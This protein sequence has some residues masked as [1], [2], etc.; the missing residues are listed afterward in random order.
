M[1]VTGVGFELF[2]APLDVLFASREHEIDQAC[3]LMSSGFDGSWFV[4]SSQ[5]RAMSCADEGLASAGVD[6]GHSQGLSGAVDEL[7]SAPGE[8]FLSAN[9]RPWS[10]R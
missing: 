2:D 9:A 10:E 6:G 1:T 5:A 7:W 8:F 4:E 3:K